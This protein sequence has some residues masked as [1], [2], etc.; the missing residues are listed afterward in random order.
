[1]YTVSINSRVAYSTQGL[2]VWHGLTG[3]FF[4]FRRLA[5]EVPKT[6]GLAEAG[7][8]YLSLREAATFITGRALW[9]QS[10]DTTVLKNLKLLSTKPRGESEVCFERCASVTIEWDHW[11]ARCP[12]HSCDPAPHSISPPLFVH[13]TLSAFNQ[14]HVTER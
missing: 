1:M 7:Q 9:K 8:C 4:F 12:S 14:S 6:I 10:R 3:R 13:P 2:K 5:A 11:M